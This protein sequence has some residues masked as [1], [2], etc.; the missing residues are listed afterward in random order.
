MV[1]GEAEADAAG[2]RRGPDREALALGEGDA[3]IPGAAGVDVGA[4]DEDR[5]GGGVEGGGEGAHRLRVGAGAAADLAVDRRLRVAGVDLHPPVVHRQRDEDGAARRQ[6]GE[7][8]AVGEGQ[9]HV[10]G[11]R[12]LVGPLDQRV[13]H[14]RR[15]AVGQVRLQ[16]D[17]GP[18]L[19]TGGD[20]QRRV[21]GLRVEDRPHRV[22]DAGRGV[23]VD[24]GGVAG[25]LGEAVGHPDHDR[26]LQAE[27]IA[28]VRGVVG[29][30]RQ[31]GRAGVAEHRR[32]PVGTEEVERRVADRRHRHEPYP[33]LADPPAARIVA[34]RERGRS[35]V[36]GLDGGPSITRG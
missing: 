2:R 13:R 35:S 32:H 15:V 28:K 16:G 9:R 21:V 29:Q 30:H 36:Q 34:T 4:G 25:G 1:L 27:H 7:V 26:L 12:R 22:A 10:L 19:L 20:Q 14:P 17:L 18:R 23:E 31:L 8:G 33:V 24:D 3:E 6:A 11:P 5:V